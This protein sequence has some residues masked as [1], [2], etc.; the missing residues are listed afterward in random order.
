MTLDGT[1]AVTTVY[2]VVPEFSVTVA[3]PI[4][5]LASGWVTTPR[6]IAVEDCMVVP[7]P[8]EVTVAPWEPGV[9]APVASRDTE[10]VWDA[11]SLR[12]KVIVYVPGTAR[13]LADHAPGWLPFWP[14]SVTVCTVSWPFVMVTE[15][16]GA[17]LVPVAVCE[18]T[19]PFR[20][21][22]DCPSVMTTPVNFWPALRL[23]VTVCEA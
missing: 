23:R 4:G 2:V 16:P 3:S 8:L 5:W 19:E 9:I 6:T 13:P 14:V 21:P 22:K 18:I 10:T 15:T 11:R 20:V 1:D 12:A 17:G 7:M